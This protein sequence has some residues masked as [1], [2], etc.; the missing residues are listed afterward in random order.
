M[1][2]LPATA[3]TVQVSKESDYASIVAECHDIARSG[4]ISRLERV[5]RETDLL[6]KRK[7]PPGY[8]VLDGDTDPAELMAAVVEIVYLDGYPELKT[9]RL[10]VDSE[11]A[12]LWPGWHEDAVKLRVPVELHGYRQLLCITAKWAHG[13][14]IEGRMVETFDL[15][16]Q[17]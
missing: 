9:D 12:G 3:G 13:E 11:G 6:A 8:V 16:V 10:K 14:V 1:S 7:L 15:E 2:L 4:T 17:P 5:T